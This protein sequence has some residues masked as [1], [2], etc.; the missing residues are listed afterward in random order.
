MDKIFI[1]I[2]VGIVPQMRM[3]RPIAK[4]VVDQIKQTDQVA[5]TLIDSQ[6]FP[7][8]LQDAGSNAQSPLTLEVDP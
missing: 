5:T 3:S 2:T 1:P 7:L 4:V 6:E 8:S